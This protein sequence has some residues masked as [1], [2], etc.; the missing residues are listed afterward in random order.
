[1]TPEDQRATALQKANAV[2]MARVN[3]QK[4]FG[5]GRVSL[6]AALTDPRSKGSLT[7]SKLLQA[8][9]RVGVDKAARLC[10]KAGIPA[11]TRVEYLSPAERFRLTKV[12]AD[13]MARRQREQAKLARANVRTNAPDPPQAAVA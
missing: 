3:L 1:M 12:V 13:F 11:G 9:P 8:M 6:G 10:T 2:R 4:E 5:Q 7:I